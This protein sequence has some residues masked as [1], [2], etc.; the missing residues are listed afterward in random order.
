MVQKFLQ[1]A[2][3][4]PYYIIRKPQVPLAIP[5]LQNWRTS[6]IC[7]FECPHT[8]IGLYNI[9]LKTCRKREKKHFIMLLLRTEFMISSKISFS[10]SLG[11][12]HEI[13]VSSIHNLSRDPNL[14]SEVGSPPS[15]PISLTGA[16]ANGCQSNLLC[17]VCNKKKGDYTNQKLF[18]HISGI[19]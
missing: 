13:S 6:Y 10:E 19:G 18:L 2:L 9:D 15:P 1:F 5:Q 8:H 3:S 17:V 7:T 12:E 4:P 16:S 14:S 11:L